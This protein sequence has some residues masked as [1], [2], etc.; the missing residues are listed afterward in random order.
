MK[1][2][3]IVCLLLISSFCF[4]Q[5]N[6]LQKNLIPTKVDSIQ[7]SIWHIQTKETSNPGTKVKEYKKELGYTV[8]DKKDQHTF[9]KKLQSPESYNSSR[10]L[11]HHYNL[12]FLIY[13]NGKIVGKVHISSITGNIDVESVQNQNNYK[14]SVSKQM[15]KY[16]I[17]LLKKY[18][19]LKL[20][21][22][23]NLKGLS[24]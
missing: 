14:T 6:K 19:L 1:Q 5:A 10:A 21:D 22:E 15:G 8:L 23:V 2:V 11:L 13:H 9:I 12:V 17:G 7:F 24:T 16:L 4:S 3:L 20:V 18:K